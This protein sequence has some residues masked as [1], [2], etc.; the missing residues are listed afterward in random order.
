MNG[1]RYISADLYRRRK[2]GQNSVGRSTAPKNNVAGRFT[3]AEIER[4]LSKIDRS[5]ECWMFRSKSKE[6][7]PRFMNVLCH[8]L[9]YEIYGEPI[10]TGM[11]IDHTCFNRWC[12]NPKHLEAVTAKENAER[13]HRAFKA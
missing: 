11:T 6:P 9:S 4:F 12:Q 7:Y 13:Y 5:K 2:G 10:P 3:I 8:R 1:A